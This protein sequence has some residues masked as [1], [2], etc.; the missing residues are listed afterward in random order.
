MG[1]SWS[2]SNKTLKKVIVSTAILYISN[3]EPITIKISGIGKYPY[4]ELN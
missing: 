2:R 4:L 1:S 3:E